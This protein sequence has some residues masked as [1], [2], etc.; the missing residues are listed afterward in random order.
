M[1]LPRG[2]FTDAL[3]ALSAFVLLFV[4][5]TVGL[6]NA[7]MAFGF[8][9]AA[10]L[11]TWQSEP[12]TSWLSP[13]ASAF[14]PADIL[15][16]VFNGVLL[17]IAGRFVEKAVGPLGIAVLFVAGSYGGALLRLI[18]TAS[19]P[20]PSNGSSPALFAIIG[21]Y[22]MLYGPPRALPVPQH[23]SRSLQIGVLALFWLGIQIAFSLAALSF[24]V[25]VTLLDPIGGLI[26]GMLLARPL[27]ALR[28]RKA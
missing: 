6:G 24:E 2:R 16:A 15:F 23:L 17:L 26:A 3:I 27:L 4:M 9:P 7:L 28:Y 14:L 12:V 20:M 1:D 19:S 10:F 21:G 13:L 5:F 25:S 11:L 18:L 8:S 22:L